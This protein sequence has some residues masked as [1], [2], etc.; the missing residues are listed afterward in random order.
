MKEVFLRSFT[1]LIISVC[2]S[3][4]CHLQA[5]EKTYSVSDPP[6]RFEQGG[7]KKILISGISGEVT[8]TPS[9]SQDISIRVTR[10]LEGSFSESM[11][12]RERADVLHQVV[13]KTIFTKDSFELRVL[14]SLNRA[15]WV[16]WSAGGHASHRLGGPQTR[17]VISAPPTMSLEIYLAHGDI[18]ITHWKAKVVVVN[19][20]GSHSF[21][22]LAGS[23]IL[24]TM[25]GSSK[26]S[27]IVG[28][29][30]ID[31]FSSSLNIKNITGKTAVRTFS[32]DVKLKKLLGSVSLGTQKARLS[33]L[34]TNGS[35][36]IQTG[37]GAVKVLEHRG[38]LTGTSDSGR[39]EA[40]ILGAVSA[41]LVS[42]SGSLVLKI[43]RSAQAHVSLSSLRG[44]VRT[45]PEIEVKKTEYGS[46]ARGTSPGRDSGR[47]KLRSE[48]GDVTL[49]YF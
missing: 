39:V 26:I 31:N 28:N 35:M 11:S 17:I 22:D 41:K 40:Q 1:L 12:D 44:S 36:M 6:I 3:L 45:P 20:E 32:G 30:G 5:R 4:S 43:P 24:R 16:D 10:Y 48:S 15:D 37:E 2:I 34:E 42:Q 21:D 25:L 49:K 9:A 38:A 18:Q 46:I 23:L 33:S 27:N 7:I 8:V 14:P 47:V 13:L 29:V 19:V